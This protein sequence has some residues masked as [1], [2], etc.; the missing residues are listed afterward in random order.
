[1]DRVDQF[2]G[3]DATAESHHLVRPRPQLN[4]DPRSRLVRVIAGWTGPSGA[5]VAQYLKAQPSDQP[6]GMTK[7]VPAHVAPDQ[8]WK[9][10]IEPDDVVSRGKEIHRPR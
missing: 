6:Q 8:D 7:A 1:V 9:G 4:L 10:R 3:C 2:G 5:H